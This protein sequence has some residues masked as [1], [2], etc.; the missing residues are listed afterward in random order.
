[1]RAGA[2]SLA[3]LCMPGWCTVGL[4]QIHISPSASSQIVLSFVVFLNYEGSRELGCLFLFIS[5]LGAKQVPAHTLRNVQ[6]EC[7]M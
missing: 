1:M 2:G 5:A 4:E 3:H 7:P 6:K